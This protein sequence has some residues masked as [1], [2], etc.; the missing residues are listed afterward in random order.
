LSHSACPD[1]QSF[2]E[3]APLLFFLSS[4][5]FL[6]L[7]S[8]YWINLTIF[9]RFQEE[10]KVTIHWWWYLIGTDFWHVQHK[11]L[12]KSKNCSFFFVFR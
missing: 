11:Y 2:A 1:F 8:L 3:I 4:T 9:V 6:L 12:S 7:L 10:T 5:V